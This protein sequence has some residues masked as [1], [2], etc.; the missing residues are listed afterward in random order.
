M[1]PC[2]S[3]G[4]IYLDSAMAHKQQAKVKVTSVIKPIKPLHSFQNF[5]KPSF[6][7]STCDSESSTYSRCHLDGM[8]LRHIEGT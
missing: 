7:R 1:K 6:R 3:L 4:G 2:L 8:T 5:T